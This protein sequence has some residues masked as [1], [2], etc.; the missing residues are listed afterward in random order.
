M[1]PIYGGASEQATSDPA[2]EVGGDRE[3]TRLKTEIGWL[4]KVI[5]AGDEKSGNIA[6]LV[7]VLGIIGLIVV[8]FSTPQGQTETIAG[9][10]MTGLVA[11]TGSAAGYLFGRKHQ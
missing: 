8:Y 3:I 5:G 7:V 11:I 4:G 9:K 1:S 2:I 6:G 10:T